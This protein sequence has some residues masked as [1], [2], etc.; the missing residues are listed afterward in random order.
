MIKIWMGIIY[1]L[2]GELMITKPALIT[3][4]D[5]LPWNRSYQMSYAAVLKRRA[6]LSNIPAKGYISPCKAAYRST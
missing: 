2:S 5:L 3:L 6:A 1:P 4:F